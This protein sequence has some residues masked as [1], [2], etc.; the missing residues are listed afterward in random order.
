MPQGQLVNQHFYREVVESLRK[1]IQTKHGYC[2]GTMPLNTKNITVAPQLPYSPDL[3]ACDFYLFLRLKIHHIGALENIEI[4]IID[5]LKVI[6]V[7]EFKL[8]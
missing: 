5:Q 3:N 2:I 1:N 8:L 4:A 6:P 7:S